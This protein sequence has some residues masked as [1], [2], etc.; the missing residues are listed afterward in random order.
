MNKV[1]LE[2]L[3][4]IDIA[5]LSRDL[6][7][8]A[9]VDPDTNIGGLEIRSEDEN[10]VD[11]FYKNVDENGYKL[12][13]FAFTFEVNDTFNFYN[14]MHKLNYD[15][16]EEFEVCPGRFFY[17]SG[18]TL[19]NYVTVLY[20]DENKDLYVGSSNTVNIIF[21]GQ[22]CTDLYARNDKDVYSVFDKLKEFRIRPTRIDIAYDDFSKVLDFDVITEKLKSKEYRSSKK[23]Y[24]IVKTSDALGTQL[25]ETIYIGNPRSN[26]SVGNYYVR[27]YDKKAQYLSKKQILPPVVERSGIWQRYELS[28]TKR[29]ALEVY[30]SLLNGDFKGNI[31]KLYKCTFRN[32]VEFLEHGKSQNKNRWNVCKWWDD[33]LKFDEKANFVDHERD[34]DLGRMLDWLTTAI[35]PNLKILDEALCYFGYDIYHLLD[36]YELNKGYSKKQ[37]RFKNNTLKMNKEEIDSYI[38]EY[39]KINREEF[40]HE[41]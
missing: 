6:L 4:S 34:A 24:N 29:K 31:D 10:F 27:M 39:F 36:S 12:D 2:N 26:S 17:N 16:V 25:G 40:S 22:G 37:I 32:A 5:R 30:Q 11:D 28:F 33:F 41:E 14:V 8:V 7:K 35:V 9:G 13:W 15:V 38:N 18:L 20:N 23:S 21:T 3:Q 19:G 1:N